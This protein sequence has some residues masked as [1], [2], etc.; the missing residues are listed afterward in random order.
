MELAGV[1][2]AEKYRPSIIKENPKIHD[3]KMELFSTAEVFCGNM[4][5]QITVAWLSG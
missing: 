3:S 2:H 1:S 4:L 5:K